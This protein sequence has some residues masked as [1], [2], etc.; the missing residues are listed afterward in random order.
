[1]SFS[2]VMLWVMSS[3]LGHTTLSAYG[4]II[5]LGTYILFF[6]ASWGPVV[7]VM[8]GEIFPLSIRGL[9]IGI[10][11]VVNWAANLLVAL[12]FPILFEKFGTFLFV[13]YAIIGIIA[14]IFVQ[15]KVIETAGKSLEEIEL[16]LRV[17]SSSL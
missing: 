1:M 16:D 12:T 6:G 7:W 15:H 5:L 2:L 14:L 8:L 3:F 13:V 10:S 11:G 17:K 4:T 9:G